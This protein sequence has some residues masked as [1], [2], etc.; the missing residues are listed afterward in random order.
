VTNFKGE[1]Q[2]QVKITGQTSLIAIFC[3]FQNNFQQKRAIIT[4]ITVSALEGVM[5]HQS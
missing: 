3:H 5:Q 2:G 1:G 4:Y